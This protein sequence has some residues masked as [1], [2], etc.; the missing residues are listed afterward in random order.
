VIGPS[1]VGKGTLIARLV[2]ELPGKLAVTVSHT[3]RPQRAG[4]AD[5]VAYHFTTRPDMMAAVSRGE[6][7]EHA[8]VHG[9][10]YGTSKSAV[11]ACAAEGKVAVLEIDVQVR[12]KRQLQLHKTYLLWLACATPR[13]VKT[14]EN[15]WPLRVVSW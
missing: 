11:E 14:S 7:L 1:G 8:E 2:A 13:V 5:G 9:N 15:A 10:L 4:E 6:F 12:W 3:T